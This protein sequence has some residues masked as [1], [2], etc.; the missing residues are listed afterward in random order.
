MKATKLTVTYPEQ[1]FAPV[2]YHSFRCGGIQLEIEVG[3][4]DKIVDVTEKAMRALRA[5]SD[6]Q[7][8]TCLQ[9]FLERAPRARNAARGE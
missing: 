5:A 2:Q 6:K 7:F 1:T 9:D 3:P 4:E 8:A